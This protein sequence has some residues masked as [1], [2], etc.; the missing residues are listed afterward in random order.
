MFII[1]TYG[2]HAVK[3]KT[4]HWIIM[5]LSLT[6][7]HFDLGNEYECHILCHQICKGFMLLKKG[8][9]PHEIWIIFLLSFCFFFHWHIVFMFCKAIIPLCSLHSCYFV[10]SL[11]NNNNNNNESKVKMSIVFSVCKMCRCFGRVGRSIWIIVFHI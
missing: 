1:C 3:L 7:S 2:I 10:L 6:L 9:K 4:K 5:N 8:Q 11:N